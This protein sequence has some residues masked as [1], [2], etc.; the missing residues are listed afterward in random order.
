MRIKLVL[1]WALVCFIVGDH[2]AVDKISNIYKRKIEVTGSYFI[3]STALNASFYQGLYTGKFIDVAT[4]DQVSKRLTNNNFFGVGAESKVLYYSLPLFN[5]WGIYAGAGYN[6][7]LGTQFTADIFK[8]VFYGNETYADKKADLS[9]IHVRYM[10]SQS[11]HFGICG[12]LGGD[13]LT[14]MRTVQFGLNI[15]KGQ[16]WYDIAIEKGSVFTEKNGEYLD[17][18]MKGNMY[19]SD[20]ASTGPGAFNGIGAGL[21]FSY[22]CENNN[23]VTFLLEATNVGIMQWNKN[24]IHNQVDTTF[25]FEGFEITNIFA[26]QDST[27][28]NISAEDFGSNLKS[29][30]TIQT[31]V[32][33]FILHA[34][35]LYP[36]NDK[37][38]LAADLNYKYWSTY[39]PKLILSYGY[40]FTKNISA[41][42]T[43]GYGGYSQL[44]AGINA[45][46]AFK[47]FQL[48]AGAS[49]LL[50]FIAPSSFSNQGAYMMASYSF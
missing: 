45:K 1:S 5:R 44:H 28:N 8:L 21:N 26:I 18:E 20:T 13:S 29:E 37:T 12:H 34:N 47:D 4:K 22:K 38:Y 41:E 25:R 35:Y 39:I 48:R 19:Q 7:D 16:N 23:G 9:G 50:G 3:N 32:L 15:V 14:R 43:G 24:T 30:K 49:D 2:F 42:I 31:M 11:L 6:L 10:E 40:K 36:L 17:I 46:V 33:P 27:F